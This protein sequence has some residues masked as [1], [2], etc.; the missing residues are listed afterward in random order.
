ML[1]LVAYCSKRFLYLEEMDLVASSNIFPAFEHILFNCYSY[2]SNRFRFPAAN[3]L[4]E[5]L[6]QRNLRVSNLMN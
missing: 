3:F 6:T 5:T 2:L 4:L 1:K